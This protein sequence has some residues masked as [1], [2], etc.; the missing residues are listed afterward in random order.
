MIFQVSPD[1]TADGYDTLVRD[2]LAQRRGVGREAILS[3][4]RLRED[5]G[6]GSYDLAMVAL[7]LERE[8]HRHFPFDVLELV[9][10][11]EQ[12]V[13]LVRAWATARGRA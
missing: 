1:A 13:G 4:C 10:N 8:T 6:L 2:A 12:F 7:R 11:V 9:E 3:G 5:L